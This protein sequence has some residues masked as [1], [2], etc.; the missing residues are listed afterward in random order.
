MRIIRSHRDFSSGTRL[1][2][3]RLDFNSATCD[4]GRLLF[5]EF[6]NE[7][8]VR[9]GQLKKN[10][11]GRLLHAI[12]IRT[13]TLALTVALPGDLLFI[14][15][16]PCRATHVDKEIT[17]LY[18]LHR[19]RND[20][21]LPCA[22]LRHHRSLFSFTDFLNNHLFRR[23]RR[24]TSVIP[25]AFERKDNLLI[26]GR[27]FLYLLRVMNH[28]VVFGIEINALIARIA[29]F[30][31]FFHFLDFRF[32]NDARL[33][34]DDLHLIK[35]GCP[36]SNIKFSPDNLALLAIFFFV[37]RRERSLDGFEH[38]IARDAAFFL[39]LAEGGIDNFE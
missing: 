32:R 33:V 22:V 10:T 20:L 1:A 8:W 24:D 7:F 27:V 17:A 21:T 37:R 38:F 12:E 36:T 39:E 28:D 23:L 34:D 29:L 16:K 4:F 2:G 3:Y 25:L 11:L 30:L 13:H 31:R 5:E 26:E 15:E 14:G 6:V 9:S 35:G 19:T 18:A